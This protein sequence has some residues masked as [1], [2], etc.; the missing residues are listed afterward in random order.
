MPALFAYI[1]YDG[2][3]VV[4][5]EGFWPLWTLTNFCEYMKKQKLNDELQLILE[6][7]AKDDVVWL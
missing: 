1:D 2:Y 3:W 6:K 5:E 4:N 7:L